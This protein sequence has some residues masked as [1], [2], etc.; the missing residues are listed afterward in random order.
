MCDGVLSQDERRMLLNKRLDLD[1]AKARLKRAHE[2]EREA[3]VSF[4]QILGSLN[5]LLF[6]ERVH[7]V[8]D[9]SQWYLLVPPCC[10][11]WVRTSTSTQWETTICLM[12]PSCSA[13][14][15]SNG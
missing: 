7:A 10:F 8:V 4:I 12:S 3:T 14:C 6:G 11:I 9:Q 5:M 15:V 1:I 2:A 13:S